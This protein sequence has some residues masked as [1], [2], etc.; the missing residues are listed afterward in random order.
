[1]T[2]YKDIK[3]IINPAVAAVYTEAY[4]HYVYEFTTTA[5]RLEAKAYITRLVGYEKQ[6][7][8]HIAG[9]SIPFA[10]DEA[11]KRFKRPAMP[12]GIDDQLIKLPEVPA[13]DDWD[14]G[15][16]V[17]PERRQIKTHLRY[18]PFCIINQTE[19][20]AMFLDAWKHCAE[21]GNDHRAQNAAYD[22]LENFITFVDCSE[23]LK[24]C[25]RF[26]GN[27]YRKTMVI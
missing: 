25:I 1:M 9:R 6:H 11:H 20:G 4:E 13:A 18:G 27:D 14:V 24:G 15:L 10:V 22:L 17:N 16:M 12:I 26:K 23:W 3:K 21:F 8:R 5:R 2:P 19:G 7:E